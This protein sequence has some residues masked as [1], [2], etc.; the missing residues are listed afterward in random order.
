MYKDE[1]IM[2]M[3][4]YL[5]MFELQ[6]PGSKIC[7]RPGNI[8]KLNRFDDE[9]WIVNLGWFSYAG[10]KPMNGWYLTSLTR[11]DRVKPLNM[12][13]LDDIYVVDIGEISEEYKELDPEIEKLIHDLKLQIEELEK[14]VAD[15]AIEVEAKDEIIAE[16]GQQILELQREHRNFRNQQPRK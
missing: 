3:R 13:D 8:I 5:F 1:R 2:F 11:K 12:S 9:Q 10:N 4:G 16:K 7:V 15:L 6:A 14:E